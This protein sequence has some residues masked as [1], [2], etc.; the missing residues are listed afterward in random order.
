MCSFTYFIIRVTVFFTACICTRTKHF[1]CIKLMFKKTQMVSFL[2]SVFLSH[3]HITHLVN[4][5]RK[6]PHH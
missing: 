2:T 5:T 6:A 4:N 3:V 1:G